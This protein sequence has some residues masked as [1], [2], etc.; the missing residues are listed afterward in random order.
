MSI[1][2]RIAHTVKSSR[3]A[4]VRETASSWIGRLQI[5]REFAVDARDYM[6]SSA[7]RPMSRR[8]SEQLQ[9]DLTFSYHQVEKALA[10]PQPRRPFGAKAQEGMADV[11]SFFGA[12][13]VDLEPTVLE[14]ARNAN[15]ALRQWNHGGEILGD[16]APVAS[17]MAGF[18]VTEDFLSL[19][20]I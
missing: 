17:E 10:F 18:S 19:I 6:K 4:V 9:R 16:V 8:S 7:Y 14:S 15:L 1:A 20:H 3:V 12:S 11:L 2:A 5:I 13:R